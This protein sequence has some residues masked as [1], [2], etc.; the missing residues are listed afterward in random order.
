MRPLSPQDLD[1]GALYD[2]CVGQRVDS[3][4]VK[5]LRASK[6]LVL[7]D[8]TKYRKLADAM[9]LHNFASTAAKIG[10][11]DPNEVIALY[12]S[13]FAHMKGHARWAYDRIKSSAPGGVC[14]YC[15]QLP[16]AT[17]DHFLPKNRHYS[18]S[19]SPINLLPACEA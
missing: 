16:V 15:G 1:L 7:A 14:P 3:E 5:R 10:A 19:I 2:Q 12:D 18:L 13:A 9:Q 4:L 11:A 8:D 17:L 6:E